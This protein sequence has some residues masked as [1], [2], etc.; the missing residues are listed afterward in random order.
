MDS[1]AKR[2][3]F[4]SALALAIAVSAWLYLDAWLKAPA[5]DLS[6]KAKARTEV[7]HDTP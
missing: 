2:D 4:I 1:A 5:F 7:R 6:P 3:L